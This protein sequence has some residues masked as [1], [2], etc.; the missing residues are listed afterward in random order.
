MVA[1]PLK[2]CRASSRFAP[3]ALAL[4]VSAAV[5]ESAH[6][7]TINPTNNAAWGANIG[8]TNWRPSTAK[9]VTIAEFVCSG[10]IWAPNVGWINM[11]SFRC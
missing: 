10:Y 11:G 4:I 5:P 1:P 8:W 9:G 7:S 3:L 6:A 2:T